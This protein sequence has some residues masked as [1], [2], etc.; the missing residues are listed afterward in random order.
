MCAHIRHLR[1]PLLPYS[2]LEFFTV[3]AF[4]L[5][6]MLMAHTLEGNVVFYD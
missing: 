2:I 3:L 5:S 1:T 6:T 4:W